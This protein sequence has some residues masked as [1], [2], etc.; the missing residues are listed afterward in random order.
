MEEF[1]K[2]IALGKKSLEPKTF[3]FEILVCFWLTIHLK[4]LSFAQYLLEQDALLEKILQNLRKTGKEALAREK[5]KEF[6]EI[7]A[8][9]QRISQLKKQITQDAGKKSG[10]MFGRM[11]NKNKA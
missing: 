4:S 6:K 11:L 8:E 3:K 5:E 7:E 9:E 1:K 2:N 10:G